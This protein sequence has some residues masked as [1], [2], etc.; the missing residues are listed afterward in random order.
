[1]FKY[2][3]LNC[4]KCL[5]LDILF[6]R[7]SS[8]CLPP[9]LKQ[10]LWVWLRWRAVFRGGVNGRGRDGIGACGN[11][12]LGTSEKRIE[13]CGRLLCLTLGN[14]EI[15]LQHVNFCCMEQSREDSQPPPSDCFIRLCVT[16]EGSCLH[17][18]NGHRNQDCTSQL[19]VQS[20]EIIIC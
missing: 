7:Y 4:K 16:W 15:C 11:I 18:S 17:F 1:M 12:E 6:S 2:R 9:L 20:N 10:E 19:V 13:L 8:L 5:L 14:L 3:S